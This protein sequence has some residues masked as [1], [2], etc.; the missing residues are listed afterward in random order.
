MAHGLFGQPTTE[1]NLFGK[2]LHIV[3]WPQ[4]FIKAESCDI[5]F[6]MSEALLS[7]ILIFDYCESI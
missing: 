6:H 3:A 5:I 2:S 7:F 1:P 4:R